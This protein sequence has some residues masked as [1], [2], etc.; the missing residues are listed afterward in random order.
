MTQY[1]PNAGCQCCTQS[2]SNFQKVIAAYAIYMKLFV[3]GVN[4]SCTPLV[5]V[6][7]RTLAWEAQTENYAE[8]M[9]LLQPR[10]KTQ[11]KHVKEHYFKRLRKTLR[12]PRPVAHFSFRII[13]CWQLD[14]KRFITN[15]GD[16]ISAA[17]MRTHSHGTQLRTDDITSIVD[18]TFAIQLPSSANRPTIN[19]RTPA[20]YIPQHCQSRKVMCCSDMIQEFCRSLVCALFDIY[21]KVSQRF[22]HANH[23]C[24]I[25]GFEKVKTNALVCNL[26]YHSVTITTS[27]LFDQTPV[28]LSNISFA[29]DG[30]MRPKCRK[31][32]WVPVR[33]A[34]VSNIQDGMRHMQAVSAECE[35]ASGRIDASLALALNSGDLELRNETN[36]SA[37][38][39]QSVLPWRQPEAEDVK[40]DCCTRAQV[41][42]FTESKSNTTQT[43]SDETDA[44]PNLISWL[45]D[46]CMQSTTSNGQ[47][48]KLAS[49]HC[50]NEYTMHHRE[51]T[52]AHHKHCLH[53]HPRQ[54]PCSPPYG[55]SAAFSATENENFF[56]RGFA[57]IP[58]VFIC[59]FT[60]TAI[61]FED[62]ESLITLRET[63]ANAG[64]YPIKGT[65]TLHF[66]Y[67]L[68]S[69]PLE[70]G[71]F[72]KCEVLFFM[73]STNYLFALINLVRTTDGK[74]AS[75]GS[76]RMNHRPFSVSSINN[77]CIFVYTS[78]VNKS[79]HQHAAVTDCASNRFS[80]L[81]WPSKSSA[82]VALRSATYEVIGV[83]SKEQNPAILTQADIRND[84]K[85]LRERDRFRLVL[86][87]AIAGPVSKMEGKPHLIVL[88]EDPRETEQVDKMIT[89]NAVENIRKSLLSP[90]LERTFKF[91]CNERTNANRIC[92]DSQL[93]NL[94]LTVTRGL[95]L[96]DEPLKWSRT[97]EEFSATIRVA[98][99]V[100][101]LHPYFALSLYQ[102][103][104]GKFATIDNQAGENET[105]PERIEFS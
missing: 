9:P 29:F 63:S 15:R 5:V 80:G 65:T 72:T 51:T 4:I 35:Q 22:R 42:C 74:F 38:T 45:T 61:G 99:Y 30:T 8:K 21:V 102:S 92:V 59:L 44:E 58:R 103:G 26:L 76:F 7:T 47:N 77:R 20:T 105:G 10:T 18:E 66:G 13:R 43:T 25:I 36:E 48:H 81:S 93:A 69:T 78:C 71:S 11:K 104:L 23:S 98:Q 39:V 62:A 28:H 68:V 34:V 55:Y 24:P 85:N 100:Y 84:T 67:G 2:A 1:W 41:M 86:A 49:V 60:V 56:Q 90:P 95:R 54:Q 19:Q 89:I 96:P 88:F 40:T 52:Y 31:I 27:F 46:S 73:D 87:V 97:V 64:H 75:C 50:E 37:Q 94:R 14:C 33:R 57:D 70:K 17:L 82:Q 12:Q 79:A 83:Y 32:H 101:T 3:W 91:R 53:L 6:L 16:I